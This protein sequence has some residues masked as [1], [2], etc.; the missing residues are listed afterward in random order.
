MER[1]TSGLLAA[2]ALAPGAGMSSV[3]TNMEQVIVGTEKLASA[4]RNRLSGFEASLSVLREPFAAR[5]RAND[6]GRLGSHRSP[7]GYP[8]GGWSVSHGK[9]LARKSR[10][11]KANRRAHRG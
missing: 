1:K 8:R 6:R 4:L 2:A 9:R 11:V 5:R 10:N 7:V 3:S